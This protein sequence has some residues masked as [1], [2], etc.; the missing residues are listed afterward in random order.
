M[1]C[2]MCVW[3]W[4]F[5]LTDTSKFII[6]S[7][8]F[9]K[10]LHHL[11][12]STNT[13]EWSTVRMIG[14]LIGNLPFLFDLCKKKSFLDIIIFIIHLA[15]LNMLFCLFIGFLYCLIMVFFWTF[16]LSM[17]PRAFLKSLTLDWIFV[18]LNYI[19]FW[20]FKL[21]KVLSHICGR[22]GKHRTKLHIV[23]LYITVIF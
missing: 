22:L 15:L 20:F 4:L 14:M 5:S 18:F 2:V 19:S 11:L 7:Q 21:L 23:P 10:G 16:V 3:K 9:Y 17:S 1:S 13:P 6:I 12:V 8:T